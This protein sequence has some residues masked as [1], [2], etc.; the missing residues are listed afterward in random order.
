MVRL[1]PLDGLP[2]GATSSFT[3]FPI[4]VARD[5]RV[6]ISTRTGLAVVDPTFHFSN[7]VAPLV[8]I[9]AVS[10]DTVPIALA[11]GGSIQPNPNR[12]AIRF[13]APSL[14][15][16][17]R[18]RV[19]YRLDGADNDWID[20]IPPRLAVYNHLAPGH[21]QFRVRAWNEDGVPSAKEATLSFTVLHA[22]YQAWWFFALC[23]LCI[24]GAGG[25]LVAALQRRRNR[26]NA[27]D[28]QARFDA[29]LAERMRM[30]RDLHD[31]L[32]QGFTGI[33]LQL[34]GVRDSL[35]VQSQ[36]LAKDLAEVLLRADRTLR[37]AREMVWDMRQPASSVD[38]LGEAL[39]AS[40]KDLANVDGVDVQHVVVGSPRRLT[41]II[42]T[43]ILR[44][45]KE[46]VVNALK[47][48]RPS[49]IVVQLTYEPRRVLLEVRD[50]GCGADPAQIESATERGH[51]GIAGMRER[52][53]LYGG[54]LETGPHC[55]GGFA[56]RAIHR[57]H[58]VRQCLRHGPLPG[59]SSNLELYPHPVSVSGR[60]ASDA[61]QPPFTLAV[62]RPC[63]WWR[64]T[65]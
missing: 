29:V 31:T 7:R 62:R 10:V 37:E 14:G 39:R 22:W 25:A 1:G 58:R 12:V 45:G 64:S 15:V 48:A 26:R 46:A 30:A 54:Q 51:W 13:S 43:T 11:D 3:P 17:E 47:H 61:P 52:V 4:Q 36:P 42:V 20:G 18:M 27:A 57:P 35:E 63:S 32:L 55:D 19:E 60:N 50:Y 21:Y 41:P 56:V 40:S 53:A 23:V 65:R 2:G 5:G 33:T 59:L 9:E 44:I 24:G 6:W 28:S 16:A 49:S 34:D 38:D 8:H